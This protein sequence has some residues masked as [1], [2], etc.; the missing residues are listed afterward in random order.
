M[1]TLSYAIHIL[2]NTPFLTHLIITNYY[3]VAVAPSSSY[4][5]IY[6]QKSKKL[7]WRKVGYKPFPSPRMVSLLR[8]AP[9]MIWYIYSTPRLFP[10]KQNAKGIIP[11]S[12]QWIFLWMGNFSGPRLEITSCCFGMPERGHKLRPRLR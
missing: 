12:L 11:T 2:F 8:W 9:T 10:A 4:R 3:P 5:A 1:F 7:R 6:K